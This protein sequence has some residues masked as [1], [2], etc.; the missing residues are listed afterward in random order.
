[1]LAG[2]LASALLLGLYA[3]GGAAWPLGFVALVPWLLALDASR[4]RA[5]LGGALLMSVA[6]VA[7]VFAWFAFAVSA[8]TGLPAWATMPLLLLAAPLLQPQLLAFALVRSV[9][10][11]RHGPL[12]GSAAAIC[13]WVGTEWLWPK[14]LGDTLGHGLHP[15]AALRQLADLGGAAGLTVVLLVVNEALAAAL[16]Q[17]AR[18]RVRPLVL[19]A[20]VVALAW[21]YGALR[22]QWLERDAQGRAPLRVAMVQAN[23]VD[24]ERLRREAGAYA[25]VRRVLD[26]HFG[27]S[28]LA[29]ANARAD[30]LLWSETVYPTTFGVPKSADGA[31]LDGEILSFVS[32]VGVPLVFG[33]Y[34]ADTQAEYNA[35]MVVDPVAGLV[36]GYRKTRPFPLTEHVPRWVDGPTLR[37]LL[38]WT[39][40]WQR[41]DGPRVYPL[42]LRNGREVPVSPLICLDAVDPELAIGSARLGA[43]ALFVLSNDAWFTSHP[44]GARL[45]LAVSAFRSIET[46]LPQ[47]R[48]TTNGI[49]AVI[50]R[51]GA[52]VQRTAIGERAL[53]LGEVT[54][55]DAPPTL[56]V[57]W[58]DWVGRAAA[59][60]LLLLAAWSAARAWRT[61]RGRAAATSPDAALGASRS[62]PGAVALLTPAQRWLIAALRVASVCGLA[63]LGASM[64]LEDGLRVASLSRIQA[65]AAYVVAPAVA[66]W[67]LLHAAAARLHLEAGT[68]RLEQ[69]ARTVEVPLASIAAVEPWRVPLPG[70]GA[71][72]RLASGR[73][74]QDGFALADPLALLERLVAAGITRP[75]PRGAAA[76]AA[77]LARIR[78]SAPRWRVDAPW[79]KFGLFP[80]LPALVA[81]RLHQIIAFGGAFGEW[82]TYGPKA[83]LAA[84]LIWWAS[85]SIGLS[86]LAALLRVGVEA[87]TLATLAT[88]EPRAIAARGWLESTARAAYFLGVPAWLALRLLSG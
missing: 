64:L 24:Y 69:G 84:L 67:W 33:S 4:A 83:Y 65:F 70:A 39:G 16:A 81:F 1:M 74:L 15:V 2:A 17:R 27:M 7:A 29:V 54:V 72:L 57:R 79:F 46:R 44:Q 40:H 86:M 43:Q 87:A 85:W 59:F 75:A 66:A 61:R 50:D 76:L 41:G 42:R 31:A 77:R 35:A 73:R 21:G 63:W 18:A 26:T 55:G 9:A 5:A 68:L 49:S 82:L 71:H 14:L 8:F 60:A 48:A 23:I 78:A 25:V 6:F 38:P 88:R 45:H 12:L 30:A 37:R 80:L 13:A 20:V 32:R 36:G 34:D 52:V 53:L 19:A 10:G 3:R 11:R 58:G 62:D 22:L 56:M 28:Q 47:L 51:S